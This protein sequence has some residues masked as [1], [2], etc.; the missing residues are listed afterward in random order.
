MLNRSYGWTMTKTS[1]VTSGTTEPGASDPTRQDVARAVARARAVFDSGVTRP[2]SARH[3]SVASIGRMLEENRTLFE[4]ALYADLRKSRREAGITEIDVALGEVAHTLRHLARWTA[5]R[6]VA[7]SPVFWPCAVHVAPEPLGVVLVMSPWNYPVNLT[8]DPLVGILACGNTAVIKPSPESRHS[9]QLLARLVPKYFPDGSVQVILGSVEAAEQVLQERFDHILF[10][11]S[12]PVGKIVMRAAAEHLTPVTLELG[13]KS[14]A[15]FDDDEHLDAAARRLAWAKFTNAG[16][17][18]VS[19]DYILT[20]PDRVPALVRALRAAVGQLWGPDPA[21]SAEYARIITARHFDRLV[22]LLDEGHIE[23]GGSHDRDDLYIE[24]TV[25]TFPDVG[26]EIVGPGAPYRILQEE[27]FGPILPI[28]TVAS[29]EEAVRVINGWDKPLSLYVFSDSADTRRF[30][31]WHTSS[32]AVVSGAALVHV[33]IGSLPFGGVGASGMG[34]YHGRDS[35]RTF[36]HLK[37]VVSKPLV[38]DTLRFLNP[39]TG[40]G[41]Q[42]LLARMQRRG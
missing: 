30:F 7:T 26:R 8:L 10:T 36:S 3:R 32:G 27:I 28:L 14:P 5:P 31:E 16:Q 37:P 20:T 24:P 18:C 29:R 15:W 23:F 4:E 25:V 41:V 9:S 22:G 35:I 2:L 34:A 1:P 19:P 6:R 38:P 12:G 40:E 11:G 13:G 21:T 17:T 33:G 39:G 42:R